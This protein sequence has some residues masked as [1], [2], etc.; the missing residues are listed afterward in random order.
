LEQYQNKNKT[1]STMRTSEGIYEAIGE[2]EQ[3]DAMSVAEYCET[4]GISNSTFY[5]WQKK[6]MMRNQENTGNMQSKVKAGTYNELIMD[7]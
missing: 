6:I 2:F 1:G 7:K 5:E 3:S 4:Y